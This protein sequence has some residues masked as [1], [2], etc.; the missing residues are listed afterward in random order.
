MRN[1][2]RS[3]GSRHWLPGAV[4][5][6]FSGRARRRMLLSDGIRGRRRGK[7]REESKKRR[8]KAQESLYRFDDLRAALSRPLS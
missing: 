5:A 2:N 7:A 8:V 3:E 4:L 6:G 1:E